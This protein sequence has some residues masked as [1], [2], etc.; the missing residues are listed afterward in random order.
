M[1]LINVFFNEQNLHG[2]LNLQLSSEYMAGLH[3]TE[4]LFI[5]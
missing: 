4:G 1:R 2:I 3:Y 5:N